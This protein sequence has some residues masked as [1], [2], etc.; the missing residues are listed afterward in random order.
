M[1]IYIP[2]FSYYFGPVFHDAALARFEARL[3]LDTGDFVHAA[4]C[5]QAAERRLRN[6]IEAP[7]GTQ[8]LFPDRLRFCK[9]AAYRVAMEEGQKV[10][11]SFSPEEVHAP[12][13]FTLGALLGVRFSDAV[14]FEERRYPLLTR[15][16]QLLLFLHRPLL[17][18]KTLLDFAE[19][20]RFRRR[21]ERGISHLFVARY[22]AARTEGGDA[23]AMEELGMR[24]IHSSY[25]HRALLRLADGGIPGAILTT[26]SVRAEQHSLFLAKREEERRR[27]EEGGQRMRLFFP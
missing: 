27:L 19:Q 26:S 16:E 15:R 12:D 1:Q 24:A 17:A 6:C 20:D 11:R 5:Y 2:I 9:A 10:K 23:R 8:A 18:R 22:L 4:D 25:A 14:Y 13:E 21:N 7:L 3:A